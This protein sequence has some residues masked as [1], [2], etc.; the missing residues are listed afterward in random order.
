MPPGSIDQED[1]VSH[2]VQP[3]D[4]QRGPQPTGLVPLTRQGSNNYTKTAK[5]LRDEICKHFNSK[6]GEVS[7]QWNMI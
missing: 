6:K 1:P 5:D 4:W 3:G 7:W 2:V